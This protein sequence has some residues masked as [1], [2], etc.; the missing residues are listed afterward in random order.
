MLVP[1]RDIYKVSANKSCVVFSDHTTLV[2]LDDAQYEVRPHAFRTR[3]YKELFLIADRNGDLFGKKA[4]TGV[5]TLSTTSATRMFFDDDIP[6]T[7]TYMARYRFEIA[8]R[9]TTGSTTFVV[10]DDVGKKLA[11]Q[12]YK[13]LLFLCWSHATDTTKEDTKS[14]VPQCL[15]DIIGCTYKFQI[16]LTPYNFTAK[17]QTIT[18]SRLLEATTSITTHQEADA[19]PW[20][21]P[22][23]VAV[24]NEGT[25]T[26]G[27]K[28][29]SPGAK[30]Q[31]C[32]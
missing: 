16:K 12:I 11:G 31:R 23:E 17:R 24:K 26:A 21:E 20:T 1:A 5:L 13:L 18:V 8:V 28:D 4:T 27:E 25:K 14:T 15:L 22:C 7:S 2:E 19:G 32:G 3:S 30:K 10:F 29:N 9:D 6:E